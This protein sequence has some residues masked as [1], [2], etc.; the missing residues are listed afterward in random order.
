MIRVLEQGAY[1]SYANRLNEKEILAQSM[2]VSSRYECSATLIA[3]V[4]DFAVSSARWSVHRC[5]NMSARGE[6]EIKEFA[7]VTADISA[8]KLIKSLEDFG[9]DGKVKELLLEDIRS[10]MQAETYLFREKGFEDREAYER[11]WQSDKSDFCRPYQKKENFPDIHEWSNHIGAYEHHR[12][13][14]LYNKYKSYVVMQKDDDQ[15]IASG[16]YQDSFHEMY[17]EMT[18]NLAGRDIIAFDMVLR[19]GPHKAC[20]EM[21]GF[22]TKELFVGKSVDELGKR[23][24]GRLIGGGPGCFHLVN[25]VTDLTDA[26][27]ELKGTGTK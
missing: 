27:R 9:D 19:K 6:G 21:N 17:A 26:A 23:E 25:I 2:F 20:F 16:T 7:G 8:A 22:N 12:K 10:I 4:N 15:A 13:D 5:P 24:I 18:Y 14:N 1:I 11:F 3:N